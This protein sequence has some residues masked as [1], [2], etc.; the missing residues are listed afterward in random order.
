MDKCNSFMKNYKISHKNIFLQNIYYIE[1]EYNGSYY[2]VIFGKYIDKGFFSILNWNCGGE[3][4]DFNDVFWNT[5][6]I[7]KSLKNKRVSKVIAQAIADYYNLSLKITKSKK[8][9]N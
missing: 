3:L 2:I 7:N 8:R 9:G 1:V 4:I 5:E 6:S